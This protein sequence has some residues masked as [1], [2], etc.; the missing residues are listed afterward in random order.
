MTD[1]VELK[2]FERSHLTSLAQWLSSPAVARWYPDPDDILSWA[3]QRPEGG[4][5]AVIAE[6]ALE[7][8]YVRWQ[9]VNRD[10]LDSLGLLE[11]P[12]GSVDIDILIGEE[13]CRGRGIGTAVLHRLLDRLRL[14][15]GVPLVGLSPEPENAMAIRSYEKAGFQFRRNYS[16]EDG[17][18]VYSL[19]TLDLSRG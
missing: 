14:E 15:G 10:T 6:S 12:D 11:I 19:M 5:H 3:S 9:R 18:R 1:L 7:L 8:G 4:S 13:S 16:V 2:L 17:G